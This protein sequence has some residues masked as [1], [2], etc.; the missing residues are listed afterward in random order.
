[1]SNGTFETDLSR[2]VEIRKGLHNT[3]YV[4]NINTGKVL[5]RGGC[6]ET[7]LKIYHNKNMRIEARTKAGCPIVLCDIKRYTTNDPK[8]GISFASTDVLSGDNLSKLKKA[9]SALKKSNASTI[10]EMRKVAL[11]GAA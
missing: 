11:E 2:G 3:W 4:E 7:A 1:M 6:E 8:Y 9:L 5:Y 10:F